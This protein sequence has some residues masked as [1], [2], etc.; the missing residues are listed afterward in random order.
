MS[1]PPIKDNRDCQQVQTTGQYSIIQLARRFRGWYRQRKVAHSEDG[2]LLSLAMVTLTCPQILLVC[3]NTRNKNG[4]LR[5]TDAWKGVSRS[6]AAMCSAARGVRCEGAHRCEQRYLVS[7]MDR[8]PS[9]APQLLKNQ[10][11]V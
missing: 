10:E 2:T 11:H 3:A 5:P 1:L 7:H 9:L 4:T 8:Q 6:R